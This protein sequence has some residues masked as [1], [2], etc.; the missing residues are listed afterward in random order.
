MSDRKRIKICICISVLLLAA[1]VATHI[2]LGHYLKTAHLID[3][4]FAHYSGI[5]LPELM[6]IEEAKARYP[7]AFEPAYYN[8]GEGPLSEGD[9]LKVLITA[10][11]VLA[12]TGIFIILL[13]LSIT[14]PNPSRT[15][16]LLGMFIVYIAVAVS[17]FFFM[18]LHFANLTYTEMGEG[19]EIAC[20]SLGDDF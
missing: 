1:I 17:L 8:Y 10:D 3:M 7:E 16:V 20:L 6:P 19:P 15:R 9:A 5:V 13:Y 11:I 12:G 14:A 18:Y 4:R 2:C